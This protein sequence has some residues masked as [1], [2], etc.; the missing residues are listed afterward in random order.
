MKEEAKVREGCEGVN[1]KRGGG[2]SD[3]ATIMHSRHAIIDKFG[4]AVR[5]ETTEG[6]QASQF[7]VRF[8]GKW[9]I[10]KGGGVLRST[11]EASKVV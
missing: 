9:N 6:T 7:E 8:G 11:S 10:L 1:G 2:F 5:M 4:G 3:E